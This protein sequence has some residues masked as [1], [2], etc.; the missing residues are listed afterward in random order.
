MSAVP[1]RRIFSNTHYELL[2]KLYMRLDLSI[3]IYIRTSRPDVFVFQTRVWKTVF[4]GM[5]SNSRPDLWIKIEIRFDLQI[6]IF[7]R[8]SRSRLQFRTRAYFF[9]SNLQFTNWRHRHRRRRHETINLTFKSSS[10]SSSSANRRQA[11]EQRPPAAA[12]WESKL[13]GE[14]AP[15]DGEGWMTH[16]ALCGTSRGGFCF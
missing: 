16:K 5:V 15:D 14:Q 10:S 3:Q 4:E 12:S 2:S 8:A 6:Y 7:T 1:T 13:L 9:H 11:A